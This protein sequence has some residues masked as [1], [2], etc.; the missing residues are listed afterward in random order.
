M[1]QNTDKKVEFI[2][3]FKLFIIAQKI[4]IILFLSILVLFLIIFSIMKINQERQNILMSEK[5]IKA[6]VYLSSGNKEK[7]KEIYEEIIK[8]EN[9]FYSILALNTILEK[10][11]ENNEEKIINYFEII[12]D[13]SIPHEQKDLLILK[14]ALYL[15]QISKTEEGKNLL[16]KLSSSNSYLKQISDQILEN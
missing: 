2:D 9:K 15:L 11:L 5:F 14:K 1:D 16:K 8:S 10:K 6:N 13:L 7:S 12:Q 4:K 3:K